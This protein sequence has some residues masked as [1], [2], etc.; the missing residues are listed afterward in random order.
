[1]RRTL[2]P[3]PLGQD[4]QSFRLYRLRFSH[5]LA[6]LLWA[7]AGLAWLA[8]IVAVAVAIVIVILRRPAAAGQGSGLQRHHSPV[9]TGAELD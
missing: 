9:I 7:A 1:M 6:L 4:S 8:G 3:R 5:P 2:P